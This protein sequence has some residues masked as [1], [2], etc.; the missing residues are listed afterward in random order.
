MTN[1][2]N[3]KKDL[4]NKELVAKRD[5]DPKTW[6]F[7]ALG[8]HFGIR[9]ETAFEIYHREKARRKIGRGAKPKS[10]RSVKSKYGF[11]RKAVYAKKA[12]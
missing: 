1:S 10:P 8:A 6:S 3:V 5:S 4:R 11:I 9:P 7:A 12:A 2:T